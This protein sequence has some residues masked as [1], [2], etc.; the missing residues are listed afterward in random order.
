M[1]G[2]HIHCPTKSKS[3]CPLDGQCLAKNIIY[4]ATVTADT[5]P[6]KQY[7]GL[8]STTFKERLSNHKQSFK[9]KSKSNATELSKHIWKLKEQKATYSINWSIIQRASPYN[10][11][12]KRCNL[13]LSEKYHIMMA[14]KQSTLNKRSELISTCRHKNKH[15]LAVFGVT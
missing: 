7:I 4:K 14:P 8:T 2:K 5:S 9:A 11:T 6:P 3:S 10:P 12:T 15:K 13:C 1:Y